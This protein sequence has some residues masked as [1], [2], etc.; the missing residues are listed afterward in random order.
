MGRIS[1]EEFMKKMEQ[2]EFLKLL[3]DYLDSIR[4]PFDKREEIETLRWVIDMVEDGFSLKMIKEELKG[5]EARQAL[6][7]E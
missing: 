5:E 1:E 7:K 2:E 6:E 4:K 3:Y